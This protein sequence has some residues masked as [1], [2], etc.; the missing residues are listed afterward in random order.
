MWYQIHTYITFWIS[1]WM[2]RN[3]NPI[4]CL[5]FSNPNSFCIKERVFQ[6]RDGI[7]L[8]RRLIR[9]SRNGL[10]PVLE[11]LSRERGSVWSVAWFPISERLE[12]CTWAPKQR[13]RIS[14]VFRLISDIGTAWTLYLSFV[15]TND[16]IVT[17]SPASSCLATGFWLII[18]TCLK[19][20]LYEVDSRRG[21][22]AHINYVGKKELFT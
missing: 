22:N 6:T 20:T 15:Q 17:L 12:P 1:P 14:L 7:R 19:T 10:N 9:R 16:V 18:Q 5:M 11:L 3:D 13:E 2:K 4:N 21:A 8:V